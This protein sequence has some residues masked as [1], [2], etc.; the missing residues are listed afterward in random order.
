MSRSID[1][2]QTLDAGVARWPLL[3]HPFY[4]AWVAGDLALSDLAIYAG[5]YWRQVETFP[6][7][8]EA[9]ATRSPGGPKVALEANL[10]D[11]LDGD[12]L[13][14]WRDFAAAVGSPR[15][16]G[17]GVNDETRRCTQFFTKTAE[18]APLAFALGAIYGYESQT[19]EVATTKRHS[20]RSLYGLGD[21][22]VA[23]FEVHSGLDVEHAGQLAEAVE[24]VTGTDDGLRGTAV[25]GAEAG[26]AAIWGLLDGVWSAISGRP[27]R[28]PFVGTQAQVAARTFLV[29]H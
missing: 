18:S 19:P 28:S 3:Q 10:S 21:Q 27:K 17:I 13:Q 26:A 29:N 8:L 15:L 7:C 22:A 20:L 25:R 4:K 2:A 14:L 1:I 12:H 23:Y 5:Q 24:D 6:D 11:E 16:D 9:L